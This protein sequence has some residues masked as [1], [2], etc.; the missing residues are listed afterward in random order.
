MGEETNW[1]QF[2]SENVHTANTKG[3]FAFCYSHDNNL[4]SFKISHCLV[5]A[6]LRLFPDFT[7]FHPLRQILHNRLGVDHDGVEVDVTEQ[8]CQPSQISLVRL[9]IAG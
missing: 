8:P 1:K 7:S 4:N 5:K 3:W 6:G 9:Q 2:S